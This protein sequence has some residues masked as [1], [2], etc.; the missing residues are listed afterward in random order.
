MI[1]L[2]NYDRRHGAL[3]S[4]R[5]F[6]DSERTQAEDARLELELREKRTPEHE[7]VLLQ[8]VDQKTIRT[9]HRRYFEGRIDAARVAEAGPFD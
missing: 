8:A 7:I 2:I 3:V 6:H 9:T 1:F 4:L 5:E